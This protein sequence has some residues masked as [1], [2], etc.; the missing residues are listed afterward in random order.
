[1]TGAIAGLLAQGEENW[2]AAILGVYLHGVAGDR[3][4]DRLGAHGLLAGD[5]TNELGV[6]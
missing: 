2:E 4:L 3:C 1:M 5:I 6:I